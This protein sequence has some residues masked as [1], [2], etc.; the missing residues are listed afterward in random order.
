MSEWQ[1]TAKTIHHYQDDDVQNPSIELREVAGKWT[2]RYHDSVNLG[3]MACAVT[4]EVVDAVTALDLLNQMACYTD[5]R[6][7][8]KMT[9]DAANAWRF[10]NG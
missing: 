3:P 7:A 4:P 6:R 10:R 1:Q 8:L 5:D 9:N 2:A